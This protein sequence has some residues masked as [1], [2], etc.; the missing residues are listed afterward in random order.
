MARRRLLGAQGSAR[1]RGAADKGARQLGEALRGEGGV[2]LSPRFDDRRRKLRKDLEAEAVVRTWRHA[3]LEARRGDGERWE[4]RRDDGHHQSARRGGG[5]DFRNRFRKRPTKA[6]A[7]GPIFSRAVSCGTAHCDRLT[8]RATRA[9]STAWPRPRLSRPHTAARLH[10]GLTVHWAPTWAGIQR[11][12]A[13]RPP[14]HG[15]DIPPN[16]T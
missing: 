4:Q 5:A 3:H 10:P 13:A 6:R 8:P 9:L 7:A 1:G 12:A 16:E 15:P 11:I 2:E 14:L